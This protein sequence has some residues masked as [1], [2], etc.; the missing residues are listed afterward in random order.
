ME[1]ALLGRVK[2]MK[3]GESGKRERD[4]R[5]KREGFIRK[6]NHIGEER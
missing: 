3:Y 1:Y 6:T 4:G 5:E 2:G